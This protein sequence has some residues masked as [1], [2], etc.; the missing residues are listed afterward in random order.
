MRT[1]HLEILGCP[2][3]RERQNVADSRLALEISSHKPPITPPHVSA[4]VSPKA[5][6][7]PDLPSSCRQV[8]SPA[9]QGQE[10]QHNADDPHHA[11]SWSVRG[12]DS[13]YHDNEDGSSLFGA[14]YLPD[15]GLRALLVLTHLIL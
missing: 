6:T 5:I 11:T 2:W 12:Q 3:Q 13:V 14:H 7:T 1:Q 15:K 8:E 10:M 9:A 4:T